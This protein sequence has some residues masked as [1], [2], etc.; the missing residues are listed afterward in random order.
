MSGATVVPD[1]NT[2]YVIYVTFSKIIEGRNVVNLQDHT[3]SLTLAPFDMPHM[4]CYY[5]KV[6]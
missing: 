5:W 6:S 3:M 4:I 2:V 1:L